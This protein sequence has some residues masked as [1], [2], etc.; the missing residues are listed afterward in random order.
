LSKILLVD[1]ETAPIKA[2]VWRLFDQNVGL[3]QIIDN[4]GIICVGLKWAGERETFL[5][6]DWEHGH[7]EMLRNV[8]R[9]ISEADAVVTYNGDKFD[10]PK[11]QGEFLLMGLPSPPPVTSIDVYKAVRKLGFI[12]NKLAFIGPLL[13]M[14][15]K[16]KHEGFDLW[17]KV[18]DGDEKAQR[19]MSRY[20]VQDVRLLEKVYRKIL[21]FIKNHPH[22][23]TTKHECGAC[24]SNNTQSRGFRRT[25]HFRIQRIQCQDCGSWSEG[26]R[27]KIT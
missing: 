21:P 24:G 11:L 10:L 14:G 6:S 15:G 2:Y 9:M 23:G 27:S 5:Y 1:I 22:L 18:I 3:N 25:K 16:I 17:T 4:G 19:M 7:E 8:H 12:S 26:T 13:K 20:C